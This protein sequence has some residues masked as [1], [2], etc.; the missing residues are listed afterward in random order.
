[1]QPPA[2][3]SDETDDGQLAPDYSP[4]TIAALFRALES[5]E[6][7]VSPQLVRS[8]QAK[9]NAVKRVGREFGFLTAG[10]VREA[11]G[12]E[13]GADALDFSLRYRGQ[14]L[15]PRFLFDPSPDGAGSMRVRPLMQDLKTIADGYGWDGADVVLWMTFPTTWFA[16][17]G[18]PVDHLDEPARVLA[19]FEDE[20]GAQW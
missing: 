5:V 18:R 2:G 7:D 6:A 3:P 9:I 11:L 15:Y 17:G 1:M 13:H 10:E 14:E 8:V 16:D 19:A 4:E 20:A 12:P